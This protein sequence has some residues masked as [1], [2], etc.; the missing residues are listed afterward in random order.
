MANNDH[1]KNAKFHFV[2]GLVTG[3]AI[4][5]IVTFIAIFLLMWSGFN[6]EDQ[7]QKSEAITS[8]AQEIDEN[9]AQPE[10]PNENIEPEELPL[11]SPPSIREGEHIKGNSSSNIEIIEYSDFECP[12]C[13][14]FSNSM[15]QVFE[16]YGDQVKVVFRHF[17]LSFHANA[18]KAAEAAECAGEQGNFWNMH[19]LIF[20]ANRDQQMSIGKWREIA[21]VIGIDVNKFNVCLDSGKY[22]DKVQSDFKEGQSLNITG[23]PT[24]FVNGIP[25]KGAQ[26]YEALKAVIEQELQK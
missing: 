18:Q 12:F 26:S 2:F 13:A 9:Q 14:N 3:I 16:N 25:V 8:G 4:M 1:E 24:T 23:T 22:A 19:D 15:N 20:K 21:G 7:N 5:S 10:N 17:P 11:I 6:N